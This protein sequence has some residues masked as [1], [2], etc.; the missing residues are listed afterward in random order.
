LKPNRKFCQIGLEELGDLLKIR[1]RVTNIEH[2]L[3]LNIVKI[4]FEDYTPPDT[5]DFYEALQVRLE[6]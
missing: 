3:K 1:G 2:S 6:K 5:E 4:Y